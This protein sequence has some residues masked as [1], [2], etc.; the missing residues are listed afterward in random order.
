MA[1]T[2]GPKTSNKASQESPN[3][4]SQVSHRPPMW[5]KVIGLFATFAVSG[6][7][8]EFVLYL[9]AP[10]GQY[11][12]GYWFT[13]FFIQGPIMFAEGLVLR[14]LHNRKINIPRVLA[15][16]LT[17]TTVLATAWYF[18]YPP[19]ELHTN[20]ANEAV[21]SINANVGALAAW[22]QG[23]ID[24]WDLKQGLDLPLET[25]RQ[26]LLGVRAYVSETIASA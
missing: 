13:F 16:P 25:L 14:M 23:V 5:L 2:A 4:P 1:R 24:H 26:M 3:T 18:W 15:I 22:G 12:M 7:M 10:E 19:L 21:V 9:L 8:H 6:V 17:T 20:L 11:H